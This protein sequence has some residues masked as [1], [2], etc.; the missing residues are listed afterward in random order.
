MVKL[1][2]FTIV[3]VSILLEAMPFVL[4]GAFVASVIQIFISQEKIAKLI[5]KNYYV[6]LFAAS[7]M[8]LIFPVCECAIVPIMR[9]LIRKGV[10]LPLAITFMLAVPIMNPVVLL[11]TYYAFSGDLTFVILRGLLGVIG[12]MLIGHLMGL[13]SKNE[14]VLKNDHVFV[15]HEGNAKRERT[16]KE[17]CVEVVSHTG[18]EFFDVGKY[19]IL[20]AGLSAA[21]QFLV[22]RDMLIAVGGNNIASI[23]VMMSMAFLLSLCSEA[24]AFIARTFL[25]QFTN[26]S[27]IGFLIYGP[28]IDVKN[29]LMLTGVLKPRAVVRLIALI[30]V[31]CFGLAMLVN[32]IG[33]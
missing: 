32:V 17:K 8:G 11:S 20:G 7:M 28:M 19:L 29:T 1:E 33:L 4:I 5:P 27:I 31:V 13:F 2:G 26:G 12:A 15:F 30:S 14:N 18:S 10:P 9:R 23:L 22:P 6:G 16:F 25:G 3:L 24:D 21:M